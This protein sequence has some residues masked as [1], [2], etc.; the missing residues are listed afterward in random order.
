MYIPKLLGYR[1]YTVVSESMEPELYRGDVVFGSPISKLSDVSEGDV[2]VYT[3][4]NKDM[5]RIVHR[6]VYKDSFGVYTLGDNNVKKDPLVQESQL[7][8]KVDYKVPLI[9]YL[10]LVFI[11]HK[12]LII[13]GSVLF[14]LL[15]E[16]G[17][18][19]KDEETI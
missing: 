16:I 8:S 17:K 10:V 13:V 5:Q 6:V 2:I 7:L 3:T 18:V 14:A 1:T 12:V 19:G 11:E 9:G 15:I 4:T